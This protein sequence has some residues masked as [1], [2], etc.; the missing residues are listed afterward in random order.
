MNQWTFNNTN[1]QN[2]NTYLLP[3]DKLDF[4]IDLE[5]LDAKE[6]FFNAT[7]GA[8][9]YLLHED[10]SRLPEARIKAKR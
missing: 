7:L 6:Y 4:D 10:D 3:E 8:R 2:L 1:F 9:S 5:K